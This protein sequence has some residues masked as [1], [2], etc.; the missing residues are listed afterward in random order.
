MT[1]ADVMLIL[2]L[3]GAFLIGFF[4]GIVRG[5]I[6]LAAWVVVFLLAA[7][8]SGPVGDYLQNQWRNFSPEY[9][10]ML[11]FL[12][13]FGLL[14]SASLVIIQIGTKGSQD[15]SRYPLVDDIVGGLVGA[16]LAVLAVAAAMAILRTFYEP[17]AVS[18]AGAEWTADLYVALK[19]STIGGQIGTGLVPMIAALLG[20]LLP[21]TIR[22]RI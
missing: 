21:A 10:H 4:W 15:L 8:L 7:H 12:I 11:A 2:I 18:V 3:A 14:F 9:N 13:L 17:A 1:T 5:L 20:P 6:A 22:G 16:T 19:R